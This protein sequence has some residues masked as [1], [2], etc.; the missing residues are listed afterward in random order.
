MLIKVNYQSKKGGLIDDALQSCCETLI[1]GEKKSWLT[2][3]DKI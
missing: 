1:R 3:E 2:V